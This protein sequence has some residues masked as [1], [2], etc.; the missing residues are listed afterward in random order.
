MSNKYEKKQ[1]RIGRVRRKI[2]GSAVSPRIAVSRSNK[3]MYVQVI[4]DEAHKTLFG[5][6]DV[7]L[8][9]TKDNLTRATKLGEQIGKKMQSM[10]LT[11]GVFDRR[12]NAYHGRVKAFAEG[13]RSSGIDI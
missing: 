6:S 8:M 9:K 13:L 2:V 1:K 4:D 3:R 5:L 7:S 12:G 10:K 11:T